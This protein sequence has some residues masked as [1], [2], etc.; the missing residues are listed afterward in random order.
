MASEERRRIITYVGATGRKLRFQMRDQ[1]TG[2]AIDQTD[3]VSATISAQSLS[4]TAYEI[5]AATLTKEDGTDGWWYFYPTAGQIDTKADLDAQ[6]RLVYASTVDFCN[7]FV[8]EI[9]QPRH[10]TA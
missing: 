5:E 1:D 3:T 2:A 6:I 7:E 10:Y 4:G 9:R 8:I